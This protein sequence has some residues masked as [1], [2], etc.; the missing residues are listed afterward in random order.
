MTKFL[1]APGGRMVQAASLLVWILILTIAL[2]LG[3]AVPVALGASSL[4]V[5]VSFGLGFLEFRSL[6]ASEGPVNGK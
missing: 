3:A 4:I 2:F 5:L 6:Q 1:A